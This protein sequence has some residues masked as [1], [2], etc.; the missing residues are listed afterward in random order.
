MIKNCM[1][2]PIIAL[3]VLVSSC[4]AP[5]SVTGEGNKMN[6]RDVPNAKSDTH[7]ERV[8]RSDASEPENVVHATPDYFDQQ[9]QE[10]QQLFAMQKN[11]LIQRSGNT[12]A[13]TF[14][15]DSLFGVS[16]SILKSGAYE[17]LSR[18]AALLKKYPDTRVSVNGYTDST[19]SEARNLR[20]SESRAAAVKQAL[21]HDGIPASRIAMGGFGESQFVASNA[22]EA[23]RQRNRRIC[24]V[25]TPDRG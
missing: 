1:L 3:A 7:A 17:P 5:L 16:S 24:V 9:E 20:L 25:I 14:G 4:A 12:L 11:P 10:L 19:G 13:V 2:F 21:V 23:G 22:T 18:L 6:P 8:A 15:S